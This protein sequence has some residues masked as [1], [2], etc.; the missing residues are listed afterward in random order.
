MNAEKKI[1][2]RNQVH[3]GNYKNKSCP[4]PPPGL[5]MVSITN[6]KSV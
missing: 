1:D 3:N 2:F 4:P 6:I 5:G